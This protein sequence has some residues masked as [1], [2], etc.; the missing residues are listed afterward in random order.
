MTQKKLFNQLQENGWIKRDDYLQYQTPTGS[1]WIRYNKKAKRLGLTW[2][3]HKDFCQES[4][5]EDL[6]D[7]IMSFIK[8]N[9]ARFNCQEGED[10]LAG[11]SFDME[12]LENL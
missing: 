2:F 1:Y 3:S 12:G 5:T 11:A 10:V 4:W 8:V 7:I 6:A 9:N